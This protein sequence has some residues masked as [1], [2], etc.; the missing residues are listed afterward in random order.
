LQVVAGALFGAGSAYSCF[1][2]ADGTAAGGFVA[3]VAFTAVCIV[4]ARI[5]A[6]A[7][8]GN[9]DFKIGVTGFIGRTG[10]AVP[11]GT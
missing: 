10:L 5:Q 2:L 9:T 1:C 8:F 3:V 7:A 4:S 6:G 11:A